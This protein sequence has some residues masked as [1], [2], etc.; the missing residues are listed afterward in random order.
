MCG[1]AGILDLAGQRPVPD[2]HRPKRWRGRSCIAART[3]RASPSTRP[4]AGL[5]A[6][7]HRRPGGRPAADDQRGPERLRR[8]QRRAVRS[9]REAR[10]TGSARASAGHALRHGDHP[11]LWEEHQEG[12]FERLRGQFAIALWDER[13]RQLIARAR[14]VRH[15]AALLDA[16]GRLAALR[17]GDQ[18]RCSLPAWCRRGR[19]GAGIDHIFTF[20]ALPGPVTCF[21]GVQLLPPGHYL[22]ITPGSER[23]ASRRSRSARIGRWIFPT[24]ATRTRATDPRELG[25]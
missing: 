11:A 16:A 8:L 21:E 24:R 13:R 2:G 17:V 6:A 22:Q 12:M 5:A 25:R 9:R 3:R 10:G 14:P 18:R 4:G 15:R 7:E 23:G 20:S 19:T 1:I